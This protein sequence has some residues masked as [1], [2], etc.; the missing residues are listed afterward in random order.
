[1]PEKSKKLKKFANKPVDFILCITV[2][3]LLA[4]GIVM[5]LS[6]SSPASYAE[7]GSSYSYVQKQAISAVIGLIAMFIISKIDYRIYKKF[8]KIVYILSILIIAVVPIIGT[9][10]NGAKRWID[11]GFTSFQPSELTK[12][13][14]IV[15]YA[16]YLTINRDRLKE[17]GKGFIIPFVY[18]AP[19]AIILLGFQEHFSATLI[20]AMVVSV[21]MIVA[22]SRI[23]HFMTFG[24]AGAVGLIVLILTQGAEFRMGRITSF[25]D[26]W[27]DPQGDSWQIIQS[28]YAIGSGGMFG[29][30]LRSK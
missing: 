27:A 6:A 23:S 19:V 29:A 26:P 5:V 8:Y 16:G 28:L 9:E 18:L 1:M 4:L 24:L 2:L 14:L 13:G 17:L 21:M 11:L 20:I 10:V 7:T 30:G 25:L 12:L 3:F 15:F 22:G